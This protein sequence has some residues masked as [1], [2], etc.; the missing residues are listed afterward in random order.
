MNGFL[1]PVQRQ[2]TDSI[3]RPSR[4]RR[5]LSDQR[6][7]L[8]DAADQR[9]FT[10]VELLVVVAIIGVLVAALL[11]AVQAARESARRSSCGNNL[12]QIGLA[13]QNYH[14]ARKTFP[15]AN[16]YTSS[17]I[18]PY[19]FNGV[20][21]AYASQSANQGPNWVVSILPFMEASA[22]V[23][24]YD[25][26]AFYLDWP[27]NISFRSAN[28]PTMLCPSDPNAGI[29]Y[30]GSGMLSPSASQGTW[31]R[32]CYAANAVVND[33]NTTIVSTSPASLQTPWTT[34]LKRG[35]M[36][37]NVA[38]SMK[39]I[40]D[41]TAKTVAVAEIRAD[42][43]TNCNRGLWAGVSGTNVLFG[44]GCATQSYASTAGFNVG[45]NFAGYPSSFNSG[46]NTATCANAEAAIGSVTGLVQLGMGCCSTNGTYDNKQTGPKSMHPGGLQ[47]AFCD[48]SVHWIDDTIQIGTGVKM[49]FWEMLFLSSDGGALP[50]DVYAN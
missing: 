39:Q 36:L 35:V 14:D 4:W 19:V 46:D 22:L 38:C 45:P 20:H 7:A 17:S 40:T 28:L 42:V 11:P 34:L 21:S 16:V 49:G 10:L 29:P 37:P 27:T 24:L 30:N 15:Y 6:S 2:F 48:G 1:E 50:A 9:G 32:S 43:A 5:N 8:G 44:F 3:G 26:N 33:V 12:K 47:A 13:L 18:S 25:R 41:G 31:G 23:T